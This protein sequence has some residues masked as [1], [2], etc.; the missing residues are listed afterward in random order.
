MSNVRLSDSDVPISPLFI[1]IALVF[2]FNVYRWKVWIDHPCLEHLEPRNSRF[3]ICFVFWF[4]QVFSKTIPDDK[5]ISIKSNKKPFGVRCHFVL[6]NQTRVC[7][8][9]DSPTKR[10]ILAL[11]L[12]IW[13][14]WGNRHVADCLF[15]HL[16]QRLHSFCSGRR[17]WRSRFLNGGCGKQRKIYS[18]LFFF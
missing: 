3:V 6:C 9:I 16:I 18:T 11:T 12:C 13:Q 2:F 4:A 7:I 5:C 1:R 10:C 17:I 15:C 14:I 8:P